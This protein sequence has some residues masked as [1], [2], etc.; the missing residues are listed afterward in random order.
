M[1]NIR[2]REE[3]H[4]G[5]YMIDMTMPIDLLTTMGSRLAALRRQREWGQKQLAAEIRRVNPA[6]DVTEAAI[7]AVEKG[8][9]NPSWELITA[10]AD[11]LEASLD[12]IAGRVDFVEVADGAPPS[13]LYPETRIVGDIME[14]LPDA[15][16]TEVAAVVQ[17][18]ARLHEASKLD[19][20]AE[21]EMLVSA[22]ASADILITPTLRKRIEEIL[23]A[24]RSGGLGSLGR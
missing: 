21:A 2:H 1:L 14:S 23:I 12:F 19:A 24:Y 17:T 11:A 5:S 18:I 10:W 9:R 15:K 16:R 22:F 13:W 20:K 4:K 6:V 7:S 3:M 8:R